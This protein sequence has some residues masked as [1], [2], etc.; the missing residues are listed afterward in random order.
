MQRALLAAFRLLPCSLAGVLSAC[1][2]DAAEPADRLDAAVFTDAASPLDGTVQDAA[3]ADATAIAQPPRDAG[4]GSDASVAP[5]ACDV[6]APTSCPEPAPRY[7]D[8]QPIFTRRCGVCH[9]QDWTGEWPLD[10]YSHIADWQAEIRAELVSCSMP[11]PDAG[12]PIPDD[13]RNAILSW[14]RCGLPR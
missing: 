13:E 6:T 1:P 4:A 10:N 7:A 9:G 5:F 8:V 3:I 12:V 14:L 11:P 2:S